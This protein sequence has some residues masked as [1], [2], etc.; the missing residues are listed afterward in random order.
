[1]PYLWMIIFWVLP[2]AA[3]GY[4]GWHLWCLLPISGWWKAAIIALGVGCFFMMFL[5]FAR[6]FDAAP[7]WLA[8]AC[9]DISTSSII[10]LMYMFMTFLVLDL[11]R[12]VRLVPRAWLYDNWT[13][14]GVLVALWVGIFVY[15]NIHY[16]NKYRKTLELTTSK[17]LQHE[18]KIVMASDLHIGYHNRR[19]ELAR[20][21]DLINAEHP[22]LVLFAGDIID[23]SMRPLIEERMAEEFRRIQAPV[24]ACL[25]NH[26]GYAGVDDAV[27]FYH[28]A[29][30]CL[31][32]D[33]AVT[34]GDDLRIIGR[35]D[36]M[37]LKRK[38]IN[39]LV[40]DTTLHP[41]PST[42]NPQQYTIVLD[43]QP[44]H[45][46]HTAAAGVDF[47]LSGH[48]HHGQIWPVSWITHAIY[49]C[50]YG[51]WRQGNTLIY[52]TSGL[53]IWG[54]KFRIGT[55]SEYVVATIKQQ[56]N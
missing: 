3:M 12:L 41:S 19:A 17:P 10:V 47:Q 52:V 14:A 35:H 54:G 6:K 45:L 24:Y 28:D 50:T 46:D 8:S 9:Y 23:G 11:G 16:H 40:Q 51:E 30:I 2:I 31:L 34:V 56:A 25:G 22:D 39:E 18:W 38:S 37:H 27:Q 36:R 53:G 43:H 49:E 26:E 1:M 7:L 44:F 32:R 13:T 4:I 20:W 33:S 21:I 48:T 5:N 29:G 42:L 55:C 15:G